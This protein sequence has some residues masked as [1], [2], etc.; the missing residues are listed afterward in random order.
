MDLGEPALDGLLRAGS[1]VILTGPAAESALQAVLIAVRARRANGLPPAPAYRVLAAALHAARSADGHTDAPEPH[2]A[3]DF[4]LEPTIPAHEAAQR[5]G[6]GARQIRRL[7][8]R[9]GGRKIGGRWF[10]DETALTE[11]LRG[12]TWES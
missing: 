1:A 10:V 5:L 4:P 11:H 12:R 3:Q 7:A 2:G 8:P 6:V 9:L